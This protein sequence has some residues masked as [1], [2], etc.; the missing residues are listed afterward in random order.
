MLPELYWPL[1][2]RNKLPIEFQQYVEILLYIAI[3]HPRMRTRWKKILSNKQKIGYHDAYV[4][5]RKHLTPEI[6]R[7]LEQWIT[8]VSSYLIKTPSHVT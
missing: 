4:V 1:M 8:Q 5:I 2:V 3:T 7:P 6:M